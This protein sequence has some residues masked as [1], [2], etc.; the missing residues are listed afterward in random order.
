[1]DP[2]TRPPADHIEAAV[3]QMADLHA[4]NVRDTT[5]LQHLVLWITT[6]LSRPSVLALALLFVVA[7]IAFN[8]AAPALGLH[9]FDP[10]PFALLEM[11]ATVVALFTTLLILATQRR[12]EHLARRRSQL[13]L[14]LSVL[15]EQKIAKVI[16][17]LEE[18]RRESPILRTREDR[19]ANDM[20]E[21]ADPRHV[22]DRII[23][24]HE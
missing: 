6:T 2:T 17:L 18:Q 15:S 16:S 10:P 8:M 4:D 7:W 9:A 13:T 21:S 14:Q 12:E 24:T 20:A 19:E 11:A 3:Q 5:P 23:K 1:M 22:L